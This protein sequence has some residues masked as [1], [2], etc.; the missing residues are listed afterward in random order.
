M[1]KEINTIYGTGKFSHSVSD[2]ELDN[3]DYSFS[4]GYAV[5]HKGNIHHIYKIDN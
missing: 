4:N 2:K 5:I 1:E 3:N